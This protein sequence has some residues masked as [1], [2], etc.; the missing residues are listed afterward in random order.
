M[1]LV[2]VAL[3]IYMGGAFFRAPRL[4]AWLGGSGIVLAAAALRLWGGGNA[5]GGPLVADPLA[6]SGR[7]LALALGAVLVLMN[8]R[9]LA[10]GGTAE[11]LGSLLLTI[12]GMMLVVGANDLVLLFVGLELISIPTYIL[13]YLGRD[14]A[15]RQEATTKYFFLSILASAMLLYGFS[16]LYGAAG[17][18]YLPAVRTVLANPDALP[19]GFPSL[20]RLA[21]VLVLAGLSFRVTVVPFH[22]YAPDVYQGTTHANAA[23]LSVLPK[24]AGL[25]TLVRLLVLTMPGSGTYAWQIVVVMS[26]LT[27]TLGNVLALWQDNLRRL[28]AYSSI[29]NAGYMLIGLAVGLAASGSTASGGSWDGLGSM[30]FYLCVYAAATLGVFA[31]LIHLGGDQRSIEGID[32]L[33]GL[34]RGRPVAAAVLAT[35]LL[36]LTGLPPLAGIW[37]KLFVFGSA[38]NVGG[39]AAGQPRWFLTLAVIGVL[40]AAVAAFYYLRIVAAM[41]FRDPLATPRAEGGR[42]A[43]AAALLCTLFVLAVGVYPG[44]LLHL[45]QAASPTAQPDA[46]AVSA[47]L[48]PPDNNKN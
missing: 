2:A 35:L 32:E 44:P 28:M 37:G 46:A 19:A 14:D 17:S 6:Y 5:P 16:F 31:T 24:A 38:L 8:W 11:N 39:G 23:L 21:L 25:W 29:T 36:S 20:V 42:G 40:N 15:A 26:A 41:Y 22:F 7:W 34:C 45:C 47:G 30:F 48:A 43:W 4:W 10:G 12:A 33:A 9:P 18:T 13:L 1:L 3:A 27:M